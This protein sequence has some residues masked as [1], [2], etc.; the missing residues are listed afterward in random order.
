MKKNE[1][2]NERSASINSM[3][4]ENIGGSPKQVSDLS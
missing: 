1:I 3:N 2:H 4:Y